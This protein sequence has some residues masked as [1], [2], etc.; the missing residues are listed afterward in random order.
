MKKKILSLILASVMVLSLTACGGSDKQAA[1]ETT[2]AAA[3]NTDTSSE[4]DAQAEPEADADADAQAEQAPAESEAEGEEAPAEGGAALKVA[5][6]SSPSGVDDGSFNED[7]YNGIL[8]FIESNPDTTVTP[9]QEPTGDVAAA[10]QAVS[11]IVADY[12]VI[13]IGRA[14]V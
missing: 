5:I 1:P 7:N 12:D 9:V 11:D 4:N 6:V 8:T 3:E 2:D 10:I 13:E 14:H